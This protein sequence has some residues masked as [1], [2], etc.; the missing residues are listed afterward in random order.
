LE[1][2]HEQVVE[3]EFSITT[4]KDKHLVVDDTRSVELSHWCFTS[5][6]A[7]NVEDKLVDSLLEINKD[8]VGKNLEPVPSTI[9]DDLAAIPDLT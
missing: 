4:T 6:D 8:N 5:D 1:V 7:W 9:N 2:K 3:P